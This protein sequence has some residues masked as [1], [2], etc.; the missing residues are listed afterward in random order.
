MDLVEEEDRPLV[1][2]PAAVL[3]PLQ[4]LAHL[5]APGVH[6]RRLLEGGAR[7]HREQPGERGLPGA[8]RPVQDHR[9]GTALL[10]RGA[11]AR[12]AAQQVVLANELAERRG[13]HPRGQGKV[14]G[15]DGG[16]AGRRRVL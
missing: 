7:V 9:V 11:K 1:R 3:R 15:R 5:G 4:Y 10:D 2:R 14:A 12:A 13:P 16:L 6:R 8:R